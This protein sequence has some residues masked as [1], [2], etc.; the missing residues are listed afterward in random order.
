MVIME[1]VS[2]RDFRSK[3]GDYMNKARTSDVIIKS[4]SF[5][6][7]K[8]VPISED[9]TLMS[10]KEF[11]AKIDRALWQV[12]TGR[13]YEMNPDETLEAFIERMEEEGNVQN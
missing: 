4:R 6:S 13:C 9:D 11:F 10:K 7:F 12:N 2:S 8:L 5:G 3:M 1:V